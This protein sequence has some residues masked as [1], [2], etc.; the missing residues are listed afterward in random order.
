M[1]EGSRTSGE[2]A[3]RRLW[4]MKGGERV[5]ATWIFGGSVA[6]E[7][8]TLVATGKLRT[9]ERVAATWFF[10]PSLARERKTLVATGRLQM[11]EKRRKT[12]KSDIDIG[13]NEGY[14][15]RYKR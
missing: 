4:R 8:K 7:Q 1:D 6:T 5:A 15:T 2:R 12:L 14:N 11:S 9:A 3:D 13:K 10:E